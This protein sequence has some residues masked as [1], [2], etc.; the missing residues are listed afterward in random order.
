MLNSKFKL[1]AAAAALLGAGTAFAQDSG[2]L[3]DL[4]IKKGIINNQEGEELR[5]D[6]TKE[7]NAAIVST[8]SG[9]KS[10]MGLSIS[11]RIQVQFA[12]IGTDI[13]GATVQPAANEHF[14]L[15]RM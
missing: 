2:P 3:L 14:L 15:R 13:S 6:L 12:D 5:A 8:I 10:T 4:L 7:A 1:L 9:G 11:G